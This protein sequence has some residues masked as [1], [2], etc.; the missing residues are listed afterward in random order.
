[1]EGPSLYL[2]ANQPKPFIWRV[3]IHP[4]T[5][6]KNITPSELKK[7]IAETKKFSLLFYKWRKVFLLRFSTVHGIIF[8]AKSAKNAKI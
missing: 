5:K 3:R 7:L 4:A 8:T 1:M 2:A 6:V